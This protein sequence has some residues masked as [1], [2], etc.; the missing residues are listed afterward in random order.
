M[1]YELEDDLTHKIDIHMTVLFNG[2]LNRQTVAA[3]IKQELWAAKGNYKPED[4]KS[5][6]LLVLSITTSNRRHKSSP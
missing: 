1:L 3:Y 6:G 4:P 5:D 2:E